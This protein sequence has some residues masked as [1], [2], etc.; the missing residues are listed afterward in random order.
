MYAVIPLP[1]LNPPLPITIGLRPDVFTYNALLNGYCKNRRIDDGLALFRQMCSKDVKPDSITYNIILQ[2]LFQA[3]R[4]S[5]ARELYV[6][7]VES[8]T[9]LKMDTFRIV[10]RG[11]C[12]NRCVDEAMKMFQSLCPKELE[13]SSFN[14]M[15][16]ALLKVGR[17]D[18]AKG[19][20]EVS[21]DLF[22]SMEKNGCP[23]DSR[24]LNGVVRRLLR[25]GEVQRAGTYLT[26]IDEK[27][28]SLEAST[29]ELLIYILSEEKYQKQVKFLPEKYHS[30]VEP[31]VL[32]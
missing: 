12:H 1:T 26:K 22:Q 27:D 2:G 30:V 31:R 28:F 18:E 20:L 3:G 4:T 21:D 6:R 16:S 10:L 7:M 23:A 9:Q 25:K 19:L 11:L 8:G 14:I 24:T 5:D 32:S 13:V 29:A 17:I 15:I